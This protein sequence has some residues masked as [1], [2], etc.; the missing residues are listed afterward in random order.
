MYEANNKQFTSY[1]AAVREANAVK[2]EVFEVRADGSKCRRW[3]PAAPVSAKK[4][5]Q[6]REALA[7]RAAYERS[8]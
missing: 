1:T 8:L 7:A 5:R 2:C 4:A 3:A 6:Y